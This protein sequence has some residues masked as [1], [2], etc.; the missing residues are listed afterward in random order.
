MED[1]HE[2]TFADMRQSL[3]NGETRTLTFD[4]SGEVQQYLMAMAYANVFDPDV[5]LV[6]AVSGMSSEELLQVAIDLEKEPIVFYLG[7]REMVSEREGKGKA[8]GILREGMSHVTMLRLCFRYG[9]LASSF[10]C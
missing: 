2:R 5:D 8:E 10:G 6:D 7:L 4:P 3:A 9:I 1:S